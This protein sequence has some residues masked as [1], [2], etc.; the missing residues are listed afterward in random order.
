LKVASKFVL[1]LCNLLKVASRLVVCLCNLLKVASRF[2]GWVWGGS[3]VLVGLF[4]LFFF[5]W[6]RGGGLGATMRKQSW[7]WGSLPW[8]A[9]G[10][11]LWDSEITLNHKPETLNPKL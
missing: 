5:W 7:D 10:S 11:V 1:G 2:V 3:V 4:F 8:T 9:R 6:G